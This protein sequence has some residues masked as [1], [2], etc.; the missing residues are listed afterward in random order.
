MRTC[1]IPKLLLKLAPPVMLALLIQSIY[2]IVDSYFVARFSQAGLTALSIISPIQW[3]MVA[4]GTGTG[5]GINILLSRMDGAG[6]EDGQRHIIKTGFILGILNYVIFAVGSLFLLTPYFQISSSVGSVREAGIAYSRIIFLFSFSLFMEANCTKMLQA[7]GNM[8]IP[9]AAQVAGAVLNIALD[10][11]LIF[12]WMGCPKMGIRGAAIATVMGQTLA[13]V[14]VLAAVV[15]SFDLHGKIKMKVA[16]QIYHAGTA[17]IAMQSLYTFYVVLLNLILKTFTEDAV[18]VLGIYY[19]LQTFFLIPLM[20]LE[21]VIIPVISFHYGAKEHKRIRD[22]VWYA[23][24]SAGVLLFL[25]TLVFLLFPDNLLSI[26]S[27]RTSIHEIGVTA[28]RIIG[29][30]FLPLGYSCIY[31]SYFQGIGQGKLCIMI[32]L[33]R[34]VILLAPLAWFFGQWGLDRLWWTFPVT[35]LITAFCAWTA[36]KKYPLEGKILVED[37]G[38]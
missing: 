18:T 15:R 4:V 12:G 7:R 20:G 6:D 11:I 3:L 1:S 16:V 8:V 31:A 37:G 9:M 27:S 28:L 19:K 24:L 36:R 29:I 17:S 22:T 32:V 10:P 13:M 21:Q 35:E 33:L 2:N 38:K 25:G 23:N 14:I 26:F 34:Q 30:S 5:T